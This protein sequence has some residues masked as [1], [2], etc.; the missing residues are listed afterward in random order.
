MLKKPGRDDNDSSPGLTKIVPRTDESKKENEVGDISSTEVIEPS[1]GETS[2][3]ETSKSTNVVADDEQKAGEADKLGSKEESMGKGADTE[4]L[5]DG[6]KLDS[7]F[8]EMPDPSEFTSRRE[9]EDILNVLED[10]VI[11]M[12]DELGHAIV[13]SRKQGASQPDSGGADKALANKLATSLDAKEMASAVKEALS[14]N[15]DSSE[16]RENLF[17]AVD[18]IVELRE[19]CYLFQ[20]LCML[21]D[22]RHIEP[23]KALINQPLSRRPKILSKLMRISLLLVGKSK[24][25]LKNWKLCIQELA[26]LRPKKAGVLAMDGF[27]ESALAAAR[28]AISGETLAQVTSLNLPSAFTMYAFIAGVVKLVNLRQSKGIIE[29]Q[30]SSSES[31]PDPVADAAKDVAGDVRKATPPKDGK[32]KIGK[33]GMDI[34]RKPAEATPP[35]PPTPMAVNVDESSDSQESSDSSTSSSSSGDDL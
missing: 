32:A 3:E 1:T 29:N 4:D 12:Q 14:G 2:K 23:L 31:E 26:S 15:L 17:A 10:Q 25:D 30:S 8:L 28:K 27:D 5:V 20:A 18:K 19:L 13:K 33:Q 22:E 21:R 6:F 9:V 35:Q 24:D 34:K 11:A 7:L 16:A